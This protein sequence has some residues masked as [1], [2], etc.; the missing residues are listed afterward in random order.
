M[1]AETLAGW[2]QEGAEGK[3]FKVVFNIINEETREPV[4]NSV[5]KA[6][7]TGHV[8][9]LTRHTVQIAENGKEMASGQ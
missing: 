5:E 7:R 2:K 1:I 3:P 9:G 4:K 6:R 8:V